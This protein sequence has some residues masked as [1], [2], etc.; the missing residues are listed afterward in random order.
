MEQMRIEITCDK[1]HVADFLREL[2]SAYEESP[3]DDME[4]ETAHGIAEI[5][6][7]KVRNVTT[8][9]LQKHTRNPRGTGRKPVAAIMVPQEVKDMFECWKDAYSERFRKPVTAEQIM[10]RWMDGIGTA[11]DA[12]TAKEARKRYRAPAAEKRSR[13]DHSGMG[14]GCLFTDNPDTPSLSRKG[15]N[16]EEL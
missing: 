10:R 5:T 3:E 6:A 8:E 15:E 12:T 1:G 11:F 14:V 2:A 7:K 16:T 4:Y 9:P 13:D